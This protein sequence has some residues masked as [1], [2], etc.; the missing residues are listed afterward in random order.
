[1]TRPEVVRSSVGLLVV[2]ASLSL[3]FSGFNFLMNKNVEFLSAPGLD[4]LHHIG[5][6]ER[7]FGFYTVTLSW[8]IPTTNAAMQSVNVGSTVILR[9]KTCPPKFPSPPKDESLGCQLAPRS[10]VQERKGGVGGKITVFRPAA[11]A[12]VHLP[13]SFRSS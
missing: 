4:L 5:W 8:G 12:P 9:V 3:V 13:A 10:L 11:S 7:E 1:M 2:S 6:R